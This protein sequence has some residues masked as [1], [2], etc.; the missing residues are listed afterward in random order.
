[1]KVILYSTNINSYETESKH[2]LNSNIDLKVFT[3]SISNL[4]PIRSSRYYKMLPHLFFS[5][6]DI[7]VC[8]DGSMTLMFPDQ[9]LGLCSELDNSQFS[10]MLFRHPRRTTVHQEIFE[11][12]RQRRDNLSVML[13]QYNR[14]R[15]EGFP[16]TLHLTENN[17][18]IRKHNDLDL[19]QCE[20]TWWNEF[21]TGSA[22]DQISFQ[23]SMWKTGY[24]NYT[25]KHQRVKEEI[26]RWRQH[27][28]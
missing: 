23:Y 25:M 20:E 9:L 5:E 8:I 18:L 24:T 14:Y 11:C 10:A 27:G 12:G 1:M 13:E 6:Y 26:F 16:D 28:T 22:R 2:T 15:K 19:I 3:E 4:E 7:S 21:K 17:V